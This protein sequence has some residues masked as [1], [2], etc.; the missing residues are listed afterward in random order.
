MGK[1]VIVPDVHGEDFWEKAVEL[2]AKRNYKAIFLGDYFD[3]YTGMSRS[4][5]LRNFQKI[6]DFKEA[7]PDKVVLLLGNHDIAYMLCQ[8][9]SRQAS[10]SDF[11]KINNI[12]WDNVD[13]LGLTCKISVTRSN[14]D[15]QKVLCSHAGVTDQWLNWMVKTLRWEQSS[16]DMFHSICAGMLD[17][18]LLRAKVSDRARRRLTTALWQVSSLRGGDNVGSII[19]A[20]QNEWPKYAKGVVGCQAAA[21]RNVIQ[22]IGHS[23]CGVCRFTD[24]IFCFDSPENDIQ[25]I[26]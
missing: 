23:K 8:G 13:Q 18:M 11:I 3:S 24:D 12:L 22:F 20:D 7:D 17:L 15:S 5:E 19:W 14:G 21:K 26:D 25:L 6:L 4:Q 1:F 9:C 10:D 2:V 16:D